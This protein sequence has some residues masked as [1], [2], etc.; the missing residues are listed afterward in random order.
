MSDAMP[1]VMPGVNRS[2]ESL[3]KSL[4]LMLVHYRLVD[5]G[6]D[7]VYVPLLPAAAADARAPPA[8]LA[9]LLLKLPPPPPLL[10]MMM[11]RRRY[12]P[13]QCQLPSMSVPNWVT[14][15]TGAT[16]EV[17]IAA[18]I[19]MIAAAS[20]QGLCRCRAMFRLALTLSSLQITGVLGNLGIEETN[21]DS[22]FKRVQLAGR[23]AGVTGSPWFADIGT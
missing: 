9:L 15:L 14:L 19:M 5:F 7:A 11:L 2:H 4:L 13:M 6:A 21:Y 18:A 22:V 10:I 16:P 8:L 23:H 1:D 20:S 3:Y 12:L 17:T